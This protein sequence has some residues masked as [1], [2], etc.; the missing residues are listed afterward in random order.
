MEKYMKKRKNLNHH[1]TPYT[2]INSKWIKDLNISCDTMKVLEENIG[3]TILDIPHSNIFA[4]I[5]PSAREIR[6]KITKKSISN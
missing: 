3:S 2:R 6:K 5:S 4:D 1:L